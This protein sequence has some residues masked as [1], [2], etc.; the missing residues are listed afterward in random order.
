MFVLLA[1][2]SQ[3]EKWDEQD[4]LFFPFE[5]FYFS[6]GSLR[7]FLK[8]IKNAAMD[9][10]ISCGIRVATGLA[11]CLVLEKKIVCL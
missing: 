10:K 3:N 11:G 7:C 5:K 9:M 2:A 4:T 1:S 6:K 8:S